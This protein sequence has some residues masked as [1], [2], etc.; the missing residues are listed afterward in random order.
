MLSAGSKSSVDQEQSPIREQSVNPESPTFTKWLTHHRKILFSDLDRTIINT[1]GWYHACAT[2]GILLDPAGAQRF[3]ELNAAANGTHGHEGMRFR[4]QTLSLLN[5]RN[6]S[7]PVTQAA[8]FE[9]GRLVACRSHVYPEALAFIRAAQNDYGEDF[10]LVIATAGYDSFAMGLVTELLRR[11]GLSGLP[12]VVIASE[13]HIERGKW[14]IARLVDLRR[15]TSVLQ[16][17]QSS[18]CHILAVAE[19][20]YHD[21]ELFSWSRPEEPCAI[22]VKHTSG[23]QSSP[24]WEAAA[25]SLPSGPQYLQ[26]RLKDHPYRLTN[27]E[28]IHREYHQELLQLPQP[29]NAI[30]I[31][32]MSRVEFDYA[33][34]A[35]TDRLKGCQGVDF[36]LLSEGTTISRGDQ[37]YLRGQWF[38]PGVA[39]GAHGLSAPG[40]SSWAII[41][42]ELIR[43]SGNLKRFR[44]L[45]PR[46]WADVG[47]SERRIVLS[48]FDHLRNAG[49]QLLG[50]AVGRQLEVSPVQRE[51]V[52]S[53]AGLVSRNYWALALNRPSLVRGI[54]PRLYCDVAATACGDLGLATPFRELD[55]AV[56][57]GFTSLSWLKELSFLAPRNTK[58]RIVDLASGAL[59]L[60]LSLQSIAKIT[61]IGGL[62]FPDEPLHLSYSSRDSYRGVQLGHRD[63]LGSLPSDER[64]RLAGWLAC[65][66]SVTLV[67]DNNATTFET[68]ANVKARLASVAQGRVLA[69]ASSINYGN[70]LLA[71][72][73][74]SA[75]PVIPNAETVM[76]L[77]P[78]FEYV[79]AYSTR[80]TGIKWLELERIYTVVQSRGRLGD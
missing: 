49:I 73:G 24:E 20:Q 43:A 66:D 40:V 33:L 57:M 60:G 53:F 69:A 28:Y 10:G 74:L 41:V 76:D 75:E 17:I 12:L 58:V 19:D 47:L 38:Y 61:Q 1:T 36:S 29:N 65:P 34:G 45:E 44:L 7:A 32:C 48:W 46:S 51:R 27:L 64:D 22:R 54:D 72:K 11:A 39:G 18:G 15:K 4:L 70:L 26:W 9:A 16:T 63:L 25:G 23:R 78:C 37:V 67:V 79:P 52:H 14:E 77:R 5:S 50:G 35:L 6:S 3:R 80:H 2:P 55:D 21:S 56:V 59:D 62:R 8:L 30:G 71:A 13:L 42:G 68:L 31:D